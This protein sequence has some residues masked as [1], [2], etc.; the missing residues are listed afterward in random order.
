MISFGIP[1]HGH[2]YPLPLTHTPL[3]PTPFHPNSYLM[4]GGS[5]LR[6]V[7][8]VLHAGLAAAMPFVNVLF[9]GLVGAHLR[10]GLL[11]GLAPFAVLLAA[12]RIAGVAFGCLAG[13]VAGRVPPALR[14]RLWQGMVTQAGIALGLCQV[15]AR[16][17]PDWGLHVAALIAGSI[18]V[19]L[20]VGP[21]LFKVAGQGMMRR[22]LGWA[23]CGSR[24]G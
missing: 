4:G 12:A 19:N 18:I 6:D 3:L 14:T 22:G 11:A 1:L 16:R 5:G 24:R 21:L 7:S 20:L 15:I 8:Q 9:F 10:L 13:G 17:L 23:V 2:T